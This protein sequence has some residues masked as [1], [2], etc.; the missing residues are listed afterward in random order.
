MHYSYHMTNLNINIRCWSSRST[1]IWF[2]LLN[3]NTRFTA[4]C[5]WC[6][7]I[8]C[9]R[10][11]FLGAWLYSNSWILLLIRI[12]IKCTSFFLY[13]D[14]LQLFFKMKA[15]YYLHIKVKLI[16]TIFVLKSFSIDNWYES[17]KKIF[18]IKS[19]KYY[20]I[21]SKTIKLL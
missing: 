5:R 3:I 2:L 16:D 4:R 21:H 9:F 10:T 6:I 8:A 13:I 20:I 12:V 18:T 7:T 11:G 1:I 19:E 15:F 17:K 14:F